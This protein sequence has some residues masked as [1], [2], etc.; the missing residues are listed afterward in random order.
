VLVFAYEYLT[1]IAV[2]NYFQQ[3][4]ETAA[5]NYVVVSGSFALQ[6]PL[7]LEQLCMQDSSSFTLETIS[8]GE[9]MNNSG[10]V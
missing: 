10:S 1:S 6:Q 5:S 7:T 3:G 8:Q 9:I 4:G 2:N